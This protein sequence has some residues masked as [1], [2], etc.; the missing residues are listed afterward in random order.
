MGF[1]NNNYARGIILGDLDIYQILILEIMR[2][3]KI[4]LTSKKKSSNQPNQTQHSKNWSN[5]IAIT[6]PWWG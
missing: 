4:R 5:W 1:P 2:E 6:D 3:F